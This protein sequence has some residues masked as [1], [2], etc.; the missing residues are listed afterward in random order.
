M[1]AIEIKSKT[2]HA[3]HI[4]LDYQLGRSDQNVRILIILED[5]SYEQEEEKLWIDSLTKNPAFNFLNEPEED[6]YSLK[7]SCD[8][9]KDQSAV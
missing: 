9:R 3:G 8:K 4:K 6:V 2:D 7:D 1:R 5:E